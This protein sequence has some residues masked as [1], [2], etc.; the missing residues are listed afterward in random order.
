MH[1]I[2]H[3]LKI[4]LDQATFQGVG[5]EVKRVLIKE[6]LQDYVLHAIYTHPDLQQLI[7]IGGTA[8]RKL[9]QL[10]RMSEDLDFVSENAVDLGKIADQ[11]ERYF[12]GIQFSAVST[13][14][15]S[16]DQVHRVTVKFAILFDLELSPLVDERVHVKVEL[17]QDS[18][19]FAT[20][21]TLHQTKGLLIPIKHYPLETMMAG[22]M[23]ACLTRVWQKGDTAI[24]VKGRDYYDLLW[25]MQKA[26]Q[27]NYD[28][29]ESSQLPVQRG[30][31]WSL[32]DKK[33]QQ[34]LP[35]DLLADLQPYFT[36]GGAITTW[37]NQFATLYQEYRRNYTATSPR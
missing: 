4:Q 1:P 29:L 16:S 12:A 8:L 2:I 18:R 37:C 7:F 32:L 10:P 23:L 15:Q 17:T 33:V 20:I 35:S 28:F 19:R 36:D 13:H 30:E 11:V 31:V 5:D 3:Q 27:P 34:I 26:V 6:Y 9:Y 24:R 25:Y 22:K 21:T 14:V